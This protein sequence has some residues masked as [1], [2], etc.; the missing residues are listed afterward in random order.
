MIIKNSR[1]EWTLF[2]DQLRWVWVDAAY[3]PH[4][5]EKPLLSGA[6]CEAT[7]RAHR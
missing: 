3:V 6:V 5:R 4:K 1:G 2:F 7:G